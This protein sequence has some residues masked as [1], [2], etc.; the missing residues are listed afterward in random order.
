MLIMA[1]TRS[2]DLYGTIIWS[3]SSLRMLHRDDGPAIQRRNGDMVWYS[4][5]KIHRNNGP[6]FYNNQTDYQAWYHYDIIHS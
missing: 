3:F 4:Y 2:I 6:A 1:A 5:G